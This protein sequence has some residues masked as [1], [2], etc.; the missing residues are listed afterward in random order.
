MKRFVQIEYQLFVK[1]VQY[2]LIDPTVDPYLKYWIE[3]GLKD[4]VRA[5]QRQQFYAEYKRA[6]DEEI[7]KKAYDNYIELKY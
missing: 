4:K 3:L 6:T 2:H 1:L 5:I 7:K